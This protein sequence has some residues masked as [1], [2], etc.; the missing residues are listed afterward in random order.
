MFSICVPVTAEP[1]SLLS[2][3]SVIAVALTSIV[4]VSAPI[5]KGQVAQGDFVAGVQRNV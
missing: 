5:C 2:V 1:R 3:C 4:S